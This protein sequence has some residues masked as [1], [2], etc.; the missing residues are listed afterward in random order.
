M[1]IVHVHMAR[2]RPVAYRQAILDGVHAAL[3]EAFQIPD[4]DRTQILRDHDPEHFE[5][6]KGPELALDRAFGVSRSKLGGKASTL[7]CLGP[8]SGTRPGHC[9]GEGPSRSS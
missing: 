2:G 4:D 7:R 5:S 1:P 9:D 6:G 3:V 8:K